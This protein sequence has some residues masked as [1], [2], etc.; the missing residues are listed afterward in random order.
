VIVL[1]IDSAELTGFALVEQTPDRGERLVRHGVMTIRSAEE[2]EAAVISLTAGTTLDVVAV[3]EPFVHP[4]N[5]ATGLALARLLGRWLQ[6]FESRDL[7]TV[8]VPAAMWQTNVLPGVTNRTRSADR[9]EAARTFA[10]DRFN[11]EVTEDE[12]DAIAMATWVARV[13]SKRPPATRGYTCDNLTGS[14][15]R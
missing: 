12:A 14:S 11:V 10:R 2:V 8:T 6:A 9:K 3:E 4:R 1:G 13:A 15:E 5:P 7:T